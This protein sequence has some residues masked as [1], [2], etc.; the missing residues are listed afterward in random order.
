MK[1]VVY[2]ISFIL[3]CTGC[4][5]SIVLET[6][7]VEPKLVVE[8]TI[9]N[10]TLPFVV[11]SRSLNYFSDL[12]NDDLSAT[13]EH[14][15]IVTLSDETN[16]S[17]LKEYSY[18]NDSGF[19]FYY[20]SSDIDQPRDAI[21]GKFGTTYYLSITTSKGEQYSASTTIPLLR[22]TLDSLWWK[23]AVALEDT[24][25]VVLF[26]LFNDPPGLGDYVRY[27]TATN[28]NN[29]FPGYTSAFDDRVVD[30]TTYT[31]QIPAGYNPADSIDVNDESFGFF[32][33][34]D[35]VVVKFS[36]IDKQSFEF[37][38]TWEFSYQSIGNPFSSPISVISN[39]SGGALGSFCGYAS[40]FK[41]IIIPK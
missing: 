26:G 4:E 8:A 22:K 30:G 39:I 6:S 37:W 29:F 41:K 24:N 20:Y 34:G 3:L 25:K 14:D 16:T 13:F 19:T 28:G 32:D 5:R 15:A 7:N 33:K 38:R 1:N 35:T 11:L 10:N 27:F 12:S 2:C 31:F 21:Y 23:P 36:N 9:E 40:Q 17:V 18:T